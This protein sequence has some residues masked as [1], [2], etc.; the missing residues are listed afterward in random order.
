MLQTLDHGREQITP[1]PQMLNSSE[2]L[3]Y[4][5]FIRALAVTM[6]VM[7]HTSAQPMKHFTIITPSEWWISNLVF[8]FSHQS[9]PLFIMMSGLLL[10]S[11]SKDETIG[12][13]YLKR[14]K[15]VI[16]PFVFWGVTYYGWRIVFKSESHTF[17]EALNIFV[18][19]PIY[20]HLWFIYMIIGLYLTVPIL[21]V[22]IKTASQMNIVYFIALWFIIVSLVP[23]FSSITGMKVGI[24]AGFFTGTIGYFLLGPLRAKISLSKRHLWMMAVVAAG[25]TLFT[26][27]GTHYLTVLKG[28]QYSGTFVKFT[29]PNIIILSVSMYFLLSETRYTRLLSKKRMPSN[30]IRHLS[31]TSLGIYF[32]HPIVLELLK[33][34][35]FGLNLS[36]LSMHA[37]IGIPATLLTAMAIS[38]VIVKALQKIPILKMV[39]P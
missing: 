18:K 8:S 13:F 14:M 4:V 20:Y 15:K 28:G 9:V 24:R 37:A 27:F 31:T 29:R 39:V 35:W 6:V 1:V 16:I 25:A 34:E 12:V 21:R 32:L 23:I 36:A 11:T 19:G 3:F 30:I 38:Y 5:D 10:L 17:Q 7:L 22:Y 33:T 26:A 2:N